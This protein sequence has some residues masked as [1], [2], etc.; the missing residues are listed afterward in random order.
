MVSSENVLLVVVILEFIL[1]V[2]AIS[3]GIVSKHKVVKILNFVFAAL[4]VVLA[5]IN[6]VTGLR[7]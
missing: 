2:Y 5:I 7:V 1:A 4:W 6:I 3:L